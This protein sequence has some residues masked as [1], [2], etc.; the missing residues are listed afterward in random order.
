M[1]LLDWLRDQLASP[2]PEQRARIASI[3]AGQALL[4]RGKPEAALSHLRDPP[5]EN[6]YLLATFLDVK[7]R[8]ALAMRDLLA[9]EGLALH[10]ET[11]GRLRAEKAHFLM[12]EA[13]ALGCLELAGSLARGIGAGGGETGED[14]VRIRAKKKRMAIDEDY[15]TL[16]HTVVGAHYR[17]LRLVGVGRSSYVISAI[18]RERDY[19]VAIKFLGPAAYLDERGRRRFEREA[20]LL[21]ELDDPHILEIHHY[22]P[23]EPP[24][25]VTEFFPGIDLRNLLAAARRFEVDEVCRIGIVLCDAVGHAHAQGIFHRNIQPGNVMLSGPMVKLI[26]FGMAKTRAGWD[27]SAEGSVLGN[28][29]YASPE[30]YE[31]TAD[32]PTPQMDVFGIGA[33]MHHLLYGVPPFRRGKSIL[34]ERTDALTAARPDLPGPLV[35]ALRRSLAEQPEERWGSVDAMGEELRKAHLRRSD[36][37]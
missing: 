14:L 36:S 4:A 23:G 35:Q 3:E 12:L 2:T 5:L 15:L 32:K 33:T 7:I 17:D 26:D 24:Y 8:A 10:A 13:E 6:L 34:R 37:R 30:Q 16:A 25:M 9:L 27:V 21:S 1:S 22:H 20:R 19:R 31:A 28:W 18:P 11:L 29:A